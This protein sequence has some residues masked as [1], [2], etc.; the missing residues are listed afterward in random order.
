MRNTQTNMMREMRRL[1]GDEEH[2]CV[3]QGQK[4]LVLAMYTD[5]IRVFLD[6]GSHYEM[7][8]ITDPAATATAETLMAAVEKV[9]EIRNSLDE[10]A[11]LEKD[12]KTRKAEAERA[13]LEAQV[14]GDGTS[15]SDDSEEH[16]DVDPRIYLGN[17][18]S[19]RPNRLA[20]Q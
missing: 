16:E 6:D 11:R 9:V 17:D 20:Q 15:S 19:V 2:K 10:P 5:Q 8:T 13:A 3:V 1:H 12:R 7:G 14:Y 4:I 18:L